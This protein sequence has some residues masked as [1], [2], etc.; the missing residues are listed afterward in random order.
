MSRYETI[1][2]HPGM[3]V[4]QA[5]ILLNKEKSRGTHAKMEFNGE[6]LY[7]DVDTEDDMF[8]KVTGM[9]KAEREQW[10]KE[11]ANKIRRLDEEHERNIP[12]LEEK[13]KEQGREVLP[14]EKWDHW[15]FVVPVRLKDLYKGF[16]LRCFLEVET[17]LLDG[18][19]LEE[20]KDMISKQGHSGMSFSLV[21]DMINVFS[22]RGSELNSYLK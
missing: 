13:Y 7:S 6:W 17:L 3:D 12:Y 8:I 20:A 5:F 16:E 21:R 15:D 11:E 22:H 4:S 2:A 19:T 10:W 14:K 9:T 18:G 1:E